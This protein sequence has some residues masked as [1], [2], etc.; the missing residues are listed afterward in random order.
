MRAAGSGQVPWPQEVHH[1]AQLIADHLEHELPWLPPSQ[2]FRDK[3]KIGG[4]APLM[5]VIPAGRFLMGSPP[6]EPERSDDEG[7]QHE[8]RKSRSLSGWGS[9]Q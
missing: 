4:D 2:T 1:L 8:V 6:D 9:T 5:V 3:L 7:P